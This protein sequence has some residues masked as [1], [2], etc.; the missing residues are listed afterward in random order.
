MGAEESTYLLIINPGS[1]STKTAGYRG[2]E[3][4]WFE[5]IPHEWK[6][7]EHYDSVA[8]QE[9][10]RYQ[11]IRQALAP[12]QD[13]LGKVSGIVGRGGLLHPIESGVYQVTQDMLDDLREA[14]YGEHASNLG[15]VLADRLG[16]EL[17]VPAFIAD[18]VV[19]DE[20]WDAAR[21]S[22]MPE[23]ERKSVFH[24]LNHKSTARKAARDMGQTYE[25]SR[26]IVAHLGGGIS[27][28]AHDRGRVVDVNNA[29]DGD[30]PF[31]P[32]RSGGVPA[33]QLARLVNSGTYTIEEIQKKLCGKG[34]VYAYLGTKN[35]PE[36][37]E[38][39]QNG[40]EKAKLILQAIIYQ[41]SKEICSLA[42]YFSGKV[43]KIILTGGASKLTLLTEAVIQRVS[44]IAPV[45]I[46]AGEREMV[47][48]AENGLRA[49]TGKTAAGEYRKV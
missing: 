9:E 49:I 33:G 17:S 11:C 27:I 30:G 45:S 6:S 47:A 14:V 40:D 19:V 21:I 13:Y 38:R 24:A 18:P 2:T 5:E 31:G 16:K 4:V 22:G 36:V 28:A 44:F 41:I 23:I 1:T 7:L 46:I 12:R 10:Y 29:L 32:E 8:D 35:M 48:L 25:E 3:E 20:M 37:A 39:S 42:A 26:F 34:G 43:D 15:A